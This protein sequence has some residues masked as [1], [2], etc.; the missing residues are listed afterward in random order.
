MPTYFTK[1]TFAFLRDLAKNNDR[2][3]FD[4]NRDR[5]E[6]HVKRPAL[7][8]IQEMA[9]RLATLSPHF[10]AGPRSL[11][12]IHRDVRFSKDKRPYKTTIGIQFR[13]DA[14]RDAHAPGYYLHIEPGG[15]FAG[16]GMW[17]PDGPALRKVRDRMVEAPELWHDAVQHRPFQD[18]FELE[19]DA[20]KRAPRGYDPEHPLIEDLKRKDFIGGRKVPNAF[21]QDPELP[22]QLTALFAAG[23]P[24]MRFLCE[25]VGVEF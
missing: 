1:S 14:G 10:H 20:L 3:W 16:L 23:T 18:A 6:E 19:G 8:F 21:V 22:D 7:D 4:A 13:H 11:F 15:S 17:H 12:R 9:P 24:F 25:A 2:T 5:Y